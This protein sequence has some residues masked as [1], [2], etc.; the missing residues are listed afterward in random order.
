LIETLLDLETITV[1]ELID[2]FKPSEERINRNG[3]NTM[4]ALNLMEDELVARLS[5]RLK[6]LGNGGLD[7]TKEASS[8]G[9]NKRGCSHNRGRGSGGRGVGIHDGSGNAGSRGGESAG[10][11]SGGTGDDVTGDECH[12]CGKKRHWAHEC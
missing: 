10:R 9:N 11:D 4:V 3:G 5:S 1:H 6:V 8:L 2:R 7:R 12:Y